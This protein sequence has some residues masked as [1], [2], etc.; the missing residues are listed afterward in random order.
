[1]TVKNER[2]DEEKRD[3]SE[4][5][6]ADYSTNDILWGSDM[7]PERRGAKHKRSWFKMLFGLDGRESI[8]K[9]RCENNVY[10]C[11]KNSMSSFIY[12]RG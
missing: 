11:I 4:K 6:A 8:D 5:T 9:T 12:A 7:Y 10:S 2:T 1:M 3:G